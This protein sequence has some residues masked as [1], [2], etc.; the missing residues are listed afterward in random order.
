MIPLAASRPVQET[1]LRESAG[2]HEIQIER[3][4]DP[5]YSCG[6]AR[7][8]AARRRPLPGGH[9]Q[10]LAL[11]LCG[12]SRSDQIDALVTLP[13]RCLHT[14]ANATDAAGVRET[15]YYLCGSAGVLTVPLVR[16]SAK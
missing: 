12:E 7:L 16:V 13:H 2:S 10:L 1:A 11:R 4:P 8:F 9:E 6:A 5:R 3:T 14:V 15:E